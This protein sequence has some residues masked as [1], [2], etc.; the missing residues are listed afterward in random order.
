MGNRTLAG[1]NR[2][3]VTALVGVGLFPQSLPVGDPSP[4][5]REVAQEVGLNFHHFIGATG[6][7]FF[8][9]IMGSGVGLFDYD[10][11]GD[12]DLA[13]AL[14]HCEQ[15]AVAFVVADSPTGNLV[16]SSG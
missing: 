16:P 1:L 9:E 15:Y 13:V 12:L 8:P 10:G 3:L 5:F 2:L 14:S 4:I 11:D 7:Y 6:E